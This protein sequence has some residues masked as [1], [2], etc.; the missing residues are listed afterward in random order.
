M[1]VYLDTNVL[2]AYFKPNDPYYLDS[3]KILTYD[4]IDKIVSFLTLTEFSSVISRL[5]KGGQIKFAPE[6]G[7]II[8]K[9]PLKQRAIILLKYI[10]KKFN[11]KVLGAKE[12][13]S[14]R[15]NGEVVSFPL[16]FLKA[17]S[18]S[19]ELGLK[20]LDNLHIAIVALENKLA[21]IDYFITG[22]R[23]I[24]DNRKT[25]L[26]LVGCPISTPKEFAELM[27]L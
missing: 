4:E 27:G 26:K 20:T 7:K 22:D 5:E 19:Y 14:L 1:R 2:I 25:I 12:L 8:S 9:M 17:I 11:L 3:R 23:D 13:I 6:I 18:L 15:V 21:R 24:I 10:V 16:E